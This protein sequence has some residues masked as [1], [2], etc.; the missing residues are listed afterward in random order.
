MKSIRNKKKEATRDAIIEA[1]RTLF[2]EH[3]Y[4]G[5]TTDDIANRADVGTGTV[6]NYF[7]SKADILIDAF[8]NDFMEEMDQQEITLQEQDLNKA[9]SE[10]VFQFIYKRM[11]RYLLVSKKI[12]RPLMNVSLY[13]SNPERLKKM[14][15]LDFMFVDELIHYLNQL[16]E[17]SVLPEDF[18]ANQAAEVIYSSLAFEFLLYLYHDEIGKEALYDGIKAKLNF[19][20]R[21]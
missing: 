19:I 5:T 16:K 7:D 15:D 11:N 2:L 6:F 20:M 18:A 10:L 17:K 3:G 1:A 4:E 9:A 8:A 14:I 13:M 21:G 12:L